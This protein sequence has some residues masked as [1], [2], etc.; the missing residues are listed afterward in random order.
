MSLFI[1]HADP[2]FTRDVI[3]LNAAWKRTNCSKK[4][5]G[6][7]ARHVFR[8]LR[9]PLDLLVRTAPTNQQGQH[10]VAGL[11]LNHTIQ[12]LGDI[13]RT[14]YL[15]G[16]QFLPQREPNIFVNGMMVENYVLF[17]FLLQNKTIFRKF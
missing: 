4:R 2:E 7:R 12:M 14:I 9:F 3:V 5:P 16:L 10:S 15:S 13:G 6:S 8:V 1:L 11:F 17:C